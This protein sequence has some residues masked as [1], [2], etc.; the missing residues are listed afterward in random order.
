[1]KEPNRGD[2]IVDRLVKDIMAYEAQ[3]DVNLFQRYIEEP[4]P[5]LTWTKDLDGYKQAWLSAENA[6]RRIYAQTAP[7]MPGFEAGHPESV[8]L[9]VFFFKVRSDWIQADG[10]EIVDM[11]VWAQQKGKMQAYFFIERLADD[12][13][14]ARKRVPDAAQFNEFRTAVAVNWLR[15]GFWLMSDDLIASVATTAKFRRLGC[16]RQTISRAVKELRLMKHRHSARQPIITGCGEG[17][18][19]IFRKGY[20]KN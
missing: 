3:W 2:D 17:G 11:L 1:M 13:K 7:A 6:M 14:N 20:P 5:T 10:S 4:L 8:A 15:Y 16:N 19:F 9:D 12:L 18:V